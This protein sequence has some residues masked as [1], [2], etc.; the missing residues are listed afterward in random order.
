MLAPGPLPSRERTGERL[1]PRDDRA[2][3]APTIPMKLRSSL[4]TLCAAALTACST[5]TDREWALIR[6]RGVPAP[7]LHK[8]DDGEVLLPRDIA[9]LSRHGVP[10]R[11]IIR[12][13]EKEGVN[14]LITSA[15]AR[16]LR[17]GGVSPRVMDALVAECEEFA[18]DYAQ[19]PVDVSVGVGYGP[20]WDHSPYFGPGYYA[21]PWW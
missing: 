3:F 5:Y 20:W 12:H 21:D 15:D 2:T 10:D 4:L 9:A 11:L 6:S 19:P 7:V 14:Y 13:L 8:L 1:Q 18:R 16:R 17:S